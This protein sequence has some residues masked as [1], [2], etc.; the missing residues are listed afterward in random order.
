MRQSTAVF[1]FAALIA[2]TLSASPSEREAAPAT[3]ILVVAHGGDAR[4]NGHVKATLEKLRGRILAEPAFLMGVPD[5]SAQQAYD[6]LLAAG[7]DRV[8]V[9]PLFVSSWSDH[10][11]QVR[12]LAGLRPDYPHAAHM[13]LSV[14]TGRIPLAGV[15]PAMDDHPH[16]AAILADRARALSEDPA[17]ESLVLVAHGPN[18][19]DDAARWHQAIRSLGAQIRKTVAFRDVDVRLLRDDAAWTVKD[20]ALHELR[21]SVERRAGQGAVI[22]VPLLMAPGSVADQIPRVLEGLAFRWSGATLL[23]D[24]RVADWIESRAGEVDPAKPDDDI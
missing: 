13:K 21:D 10:Y 19:D 22:V 1:A 23:P 7:A 16:I 24:D 12:F 15:T 2:A 17:R 4:W 18:P 14:V 20:K 5:Q 11:E 9:V 8:V 6:K 3:G